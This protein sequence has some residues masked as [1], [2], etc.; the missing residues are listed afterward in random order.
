LCTFK[1]K[2]KKKLARASVQSSVRDHSMSDAGGDDEPEDN[3]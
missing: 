3:A 1:K 2:K